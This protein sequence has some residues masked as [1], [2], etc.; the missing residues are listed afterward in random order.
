VPPYDNSGGLHGV[1]AALEF[2]V[3]ALRVKHILVMGH[4]GC[5][6]VAASLLAADNQP[7]GEFIAPWV[8]LLDQARDAII[9]QAP[10]DT[11]T[12]LERAGIGV[13]LDNLMTF[14]FVQQA[15][16]AGELE[17]HGSWFAIGSGELHWRDNQ[18]CAFE[19]VTA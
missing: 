8:E 13:S 16:A 12:G 2:A 10:A 5:G 6:G 14:P 15:V 3:T 18:T 11:Q 7:V 19:V 4:G 9:A 1:S 17:L